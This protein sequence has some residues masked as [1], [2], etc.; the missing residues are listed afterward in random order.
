MLSALSP[1]DMLR[2]F[3]KYCSAHKLKAKRT[4][5]RQATCV[6]RHKKKASFLGSESELGG[7]AFWDWWGSNST[8]PGF[9]S[10]SPHDLWPLRDRVNEPPQDMPGH[11]KAQ[12]GRAAQT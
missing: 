12:R 3:A 11:S 2:I 10:K 6:K 7:V 4:G 1:Q 5:D 9:V 8:W